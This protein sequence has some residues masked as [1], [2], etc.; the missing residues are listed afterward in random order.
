[1]A[2]DQRDRAFD[3]AEGQ[4]TGVCQTWGEEGGNHPWARPEPS[5]QHPAQNAGERLRT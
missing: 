5:T 4:R 1:M 3:W 2:L